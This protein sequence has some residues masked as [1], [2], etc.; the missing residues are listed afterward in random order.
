MKKI[1]IIIL[2]ILG[3]IILTANITAYNIEKENYAKEHNCTWH[4][5]SRDGDVEVCITNN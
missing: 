1:I 4:V 5:V 2:A 3:I